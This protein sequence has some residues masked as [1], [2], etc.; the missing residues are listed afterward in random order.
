MPSDIRQIVSTAAAPEMNFRNHAC[1]GRTIVSF[2]RDPLHGNPVD[3][4]SWM[5]DVMRQ[6]YMQ[7][8]DPQKRSQHIVALLV[9][10]LL[11]QIPPHIRPVAEQILASIIAPATGTSIDLRSRP[12]SV[13]DISRVTAMDKKVILEATR[14]LNP[15]LS[16]YPVPFTAESGL[17]FRDLIWLVAPPN[18][19]S[20][21]CMSRRVLDLINPLV[22]ADLSTRYVTEFNHALEAGCRAQADEE[23]ESP[24]HFMPSE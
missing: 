13:E 6:P 20:G 21:W 1:L 24:P 9:Q 19:E 8:L 15:L 11:S 17:D 18:D 23:V 16:L 14:R 12:F 5:L 10:R 2:V 22:W 4:L 3:R 7:S